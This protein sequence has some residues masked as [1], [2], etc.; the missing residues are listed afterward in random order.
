MQ[1]CLKAV[2]SCTSEAGFCGNNLV[3]SL[4]V[5]LEHFIQLV[6]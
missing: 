3:D 1:L 4:E 2:D 6:E 5:V